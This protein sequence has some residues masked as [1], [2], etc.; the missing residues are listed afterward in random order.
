MLN[1]KLE[2]TKRTHGENENIYF[3]RRIVLADDPPI[4]GGAMEDMIPF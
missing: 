3:N 2:V 1:I 4:Q